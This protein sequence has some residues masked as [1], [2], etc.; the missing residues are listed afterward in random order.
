MG[1]VIYTG[2]SL[3]D[4]VTNG[5]GKV[6]TA[7][8]PIVVLA[9]FAIGKGANV[10]TGGEIQTYILRGDVS[11][12][13][14]IASGLD[15][16]TCGACIHRSIA[17]GGEGTCYAHHVA[18]R[19]GGMTWGQWDRGGS[20]PFDLE[21]FK[22]RVL[23]LGAY[24]DPAAIPF[25]AWRPLLAVAKGWTGYTHQWRDCDQRYREVCMASCDNDQDQ[26][27]AIDAG[28]RVYRVHAVGTVKPAGTVPC[29]S[30]RIKCE[31][32]LKC[33]GLGMNRRGHVSI[34]AHGATAKRFTGTV[35]LPLPVVTRNA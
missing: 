6:I 25:E 27:D 20:L 11:P 22:G 30:P 18:R 13:V 17:A 21:P 10:K 32:C 7:G 24:G 35:S 8:S 9:T 19:G 4:S 14:A 29:P 5:T 23:R 16:A 1:M 28:W 26:A 34:V 31:D 3:L 33:S 12:K 15:G 2:N